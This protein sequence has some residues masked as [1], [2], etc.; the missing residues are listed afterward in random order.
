MPVVP[1]AAA[2]TEASALTRRG[3]LARNVVW[4]LLGVGLPTLAAVLAIPP[5]AGA[6]G[7]ARFGLLSLAWMFIG[8]FTIFDL[9]LSLALTKIVSARIAE[10]RRP[11]LTSLVGTALIA[12]TLV[13]VLSAVLV[14]G[15]APRLVTQ[16]MKVPADLQGEALQVIYVL[17]LSIPFVILGSVL[18]G[19]LEAFQR[20]DLVNVVRLAN[21][22]YLFIGPLLVLPWTRDMAVLVGVLALGKAVATLVFAW[23]CLRLL[24][25]LLRELRWSALEFREL[26]LFGGWITL[27]NIIGPL[28]TYT[29]QFM[30]G[31]LVSIALVG[32][33]LVPYQMITKLW[34][35]TVAVVGVL[36]PA[37][38]IHLIADRPAARRLFLLGMKS[39]VLLVAPAAFLAAAFAGEILQLWLDAEHGRV[40]GPL[41]QV[42]A[43]GVL[44]NAFSFVTL[45]LVQA[46]GKPDW[47]PKLFL[48][49]MPFYV[50]ALY[51]AIAQC[52]LMG[53]VLV[54][55]AKILVDFLFLLWASSRVMPEV[56]AALRKAV[57]GFLVLFG[58]F[59]PLYADLP[60]MWRGLYAGVWLLGLPLLSWYQLLSPDERSLILDRVRQRRRETAT[61]TDP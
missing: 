46:S 12:A 13:A 19:V 28:L 1:A 34:A 5:L 7:E 25:E 43:L 52:G 49:E 27:G 17:A 38:S 41:L 31:T 37:L 39:V 9:G 6:L 3:L 42:F 56:S 8:Y 61:S 16:I 15:A 45:A 44:I 2:H 57:P 55:L 48:L 22:L 18:R 58:G 47:V 40:G 36:F 30:I 50:P 11:S 53:A 35:V 14:W 59:L 60:L 29:D 32:Y 23:F 51:V 33:Y 4:N 54:W 24:P 21:G 10:N 20:F 26:F